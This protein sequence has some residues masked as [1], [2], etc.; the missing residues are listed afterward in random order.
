MFVTLGMTSSGLPGT[1]S[2]E[3]SFQS[4]ESS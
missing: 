4:F 1:A 2:A 3:R